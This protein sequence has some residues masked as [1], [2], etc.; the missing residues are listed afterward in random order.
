MSRYL[1]CT[2]LHHGVILS[3]RFFFFTSL[4]MP[5]AEDEE[6][7]ELAKEISKDW[8][9]GNPPSPQEKREKKKEKGNHYFCS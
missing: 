4:F 5:T 1:A 3:F 7:E 9:S 6:R 8:S 2:V